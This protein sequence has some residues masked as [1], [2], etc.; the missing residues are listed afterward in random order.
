[1]NKLKKVRLPNIFFWKGDGLKILAISCSPRKDGNTVLLLEEALKGAKK[2]GAEVELFS[3][4]GK[5][6][7]HCDGCRACWKTGACHIQDDLQVLYPKLVEARGIILGTPVY[8]YTMAGICKT[9]IERMGA[10]GSPEKS[11]ANKVGAAIVTAGSMGLIDPL[12]SIY[13]YFVSRQMVPANFVAAYTASD[14]R[15]MQ[16]CMNATRD[17]GRQMV[18]IASQ[19]FQYPKDISRSGVAYGTHTR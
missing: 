9:V 5:K 16:K 3:V 14:P 10:L 8:G 4:A 17:L 11:L 12:K 19:N 7:E 18:L 2:E 1:M 15:E 13:F 6:I